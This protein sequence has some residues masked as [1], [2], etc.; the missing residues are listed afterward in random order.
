MKTILLIFLFTSLILSQTKISSDQIS[1]MNGKTLLPLKTDNCWYFE[2]SLY[3]NDT[4]FKTI[5]DSI[6]VKKDTLLNSIPG[7]FLSTDP[8]SVLFQDNEGLWAYI[9]KTQK[10][11]LF[12]KYPCSADESWPISIL[13]MKGNI[14]VISLNEKVNV[15]DRTYECLHYNLKTNYGESADIFINPSIGFI[16]V[17]FYKLKNKNFEINLVKYKLN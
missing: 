13:E 9:L 6:Y 12:L 16:K 3:K 5:N 14:T 7:Y 4:L 15:K 17:T 2:R 1:L 8:K 11:Y 10:K